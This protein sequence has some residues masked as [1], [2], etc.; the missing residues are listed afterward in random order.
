[1]VNLANV[2]TRDGCGLRY[3][4]SGGS[5]RAIVLTHGAGAD[6]HTFD[7]QFV[8]LV[9]G[10]QRVVVWDMRLHGESA[11]SD[12]PFTKASALG[13]LAALIAHLG[14]IRPVI[15]GHSLGG[16][17]AQA[18]V[19]GDPHR[20]AG[21]IVMDSTWNSGPLTRTERLLLRLAA[22]SLALIPARS[23]PR[24]MAR[25]SAVT[26][27]ARDDATRA[28]SQLSKRQ[29]I[30]VWRATVAFLE[31]DPTYR[32]PIPLC[33]VRGAEDRTGNIA[34]AMPLWAATEGVIEH[35]VPG[36]GH[37]VTQDAPEL[38]TAII[39]EFLD[40]LSPEA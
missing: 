4:D 7:Q 18:L 24:L 28:F 5:G 15:A 26:P 37:L 14:L 39:R 19:R 10:G 36:A 20:F 35:V 13:D 23:L 33:L 38:A 25:A 1:M 32:T 22:P 11:P 40:D 16:N 12:V 29:F 2:L 34:T 30:E 9:A 27:A 3:V 31:P 6:H 17:L 8:S 21:I